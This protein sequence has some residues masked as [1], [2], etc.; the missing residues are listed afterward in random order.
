MT[1]GDFS[2]WGGVISLLT[3]ALKFIDYFCEKKSRILDWPY[4]KFA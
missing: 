4:K 3:A 1:S 2:F